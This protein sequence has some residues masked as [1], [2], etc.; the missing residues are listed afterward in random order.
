MSG[1]DDDSL[2]E[3]VYLVALLALLLGAFGFRRR[4]FAAG[5]RH[6][7]VWAL[8][9]LALI[10]VYAYREPLLRFAAP[11]L[12]E[13]SPSRVAVVTS[14][15]GARELVVRRGGDGH[16]HVAGETGGA[17]IRFLVDT[18]ASLTVLTRRDAERGG[19]DVDALNYTR[20]VQTA[21]GRAF[22]APARLEAL[23]I[24][25]YRLEELPVG[26]MPDG[27]LDTSLLGMSTLDR[28]S[29]WRI[30]GDRLMLTP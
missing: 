24:G 6:L 8:V 22:Y 19:I 15:D 17:T 11:V 26:V 21:N 12:D 27:A 16:F 7:T 28:F 3:F 29:G 1:L 25:P 10:A 23:S 30:E 9:I 5:L 2:L 14:A 4:R 20:P 18:G 13:L